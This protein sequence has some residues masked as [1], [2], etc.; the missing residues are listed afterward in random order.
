MDGFRAALFCQ[1]DGKVVIQSRHQRSLTR[2]FTDVVDTVATCLSPGTVLDGELVVMAG[3]RVDFAALQRRL[4]SRRIEAPA[5]LVAFDVLARDGED[6]RG[7][8]C[9]TRRELL[10]QLIPDGQTGLAVVP[11]T[12]DPLAAAVWMS[13]GERGIEGVVSKNVNHS[14]NPHR[15]RWH[16]IRARVTSE[17]IVGGVIGSLEAPRAVIVGRHDARDRLRIVGRSV[18][19]PKQVS[20]QLGGLL[21]PARGSHPWPTEIPS[22]RLGLPGGAPVT[23]TPVQPELVVEIDTDQSVEAGRYRHAVRVVRL[24]LDLTAADLGSW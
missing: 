11:M 21:R 4:A 2:A 15:H 17:A 6:V 24:R 5:T 13:H 10:E 3:G 8:P 23:Y 9:H 22:G 18:S 14:Y 7:L 16:K 20:G 12:T 1:A 19:L